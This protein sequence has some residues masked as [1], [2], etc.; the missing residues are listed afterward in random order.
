MLKAWSES[1]NQHPEVTC[2]TFQQALHDYER[3]GNRLALSYFRAV[4]AD[5]YR[6]AGQ[7]ENAQRVLETALSEASDTGEGFFTAELLRLKGELALSLNSQD[8]VNAESF[9]IHAYEHAIRQ[10][11]PT[12]ALRAATSLVRLISR[13]KNDT[14]ATNRLQTPLDEA[15]IHLNNLLALFI[16]D[17][18]TADA[19]IAEQ[20]LSSLNSGDAAVNH[21]E[22]TPA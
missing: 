3:S 16:E 15:K 5:L 8:D 9:F 21:S 11:S 1:L 13:Q 4:L 19:V 10:D 12:L 20:L 22:K 14:A 2:Q 6:A 17:K 7:L 18:C